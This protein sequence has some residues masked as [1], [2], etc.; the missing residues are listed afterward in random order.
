MQEPAGFGVA[1]DSSRALYQLVKF[2]VRLG[3]SSR[4]GTSY[5]RQRIKNK[6]VARKSP[7]RFNMM[8]ATTIGD[9][10][11]SEYELRADFP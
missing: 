2:G 9:A 4:G 5:S 8:E 6:E 3:S 10:C 11:C 1:D 7:I